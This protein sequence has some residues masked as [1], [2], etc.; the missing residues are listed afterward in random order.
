[1]LLLFPPPAIHPPTFSNLCILIENLHIGQ[2]VTAN[3]V[4]AADIWNRDWRTAKGGMDIYVAVCS[5]TPTSAIPLHYCIT[6]FTRS[7]AR[8]KKKSHKRKSCRLLEMMMIDIC[9]DIYIYWPSHPTLDSQTAHGL[10]AV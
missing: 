3:A 9:I 6:K 10:F 2:G 4:V 8:V 1:V 5:I 7:Q